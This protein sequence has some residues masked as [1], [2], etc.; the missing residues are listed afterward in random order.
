MQATEDCQEQEASDL[1]D[2]TAALLS[3]HITS[4]AISVVAA[5][6]P[7]CHSLLPVA[8]QIWWCRGLCNRRATTIAGGVWWAVFVT[9]GVCNFVHTV[10]L[11]LDGNDIFV[12]PM[13]TNRT[14]NYLLRCKAQSRVL[15]TAWV[16]NGNMETS[17]PHS[18]ET[19]QVITMKLCTFET[20]TLAKFGWNPPARSRSTHTWNIHLLCLLPSFL[21]AFFSCIPAQAKRLEII[22]RTTTQKTQF[23]P[24]IEFFLSFDVL[25]D[26]L[27]K[28]LEFRP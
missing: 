24:S 4:L 2:T 20:N 15:R 3:T 18:S 28:P 17:I 13:H 21:P 16:P 9:N 23:G 10:Q 1:A 11:F 8:E 27:P 25:G 7:K 22:S 19:S 5:N 12:C 26:I 14:I 6:R